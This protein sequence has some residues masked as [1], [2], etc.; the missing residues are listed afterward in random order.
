MSGGIERLLARARDRRGELFKDEDTDVYRLVNG[1]GDGIPG[2]FLDRYG[3]FGV[4]RMESARLR[5]EAYA[6]YAA[7]LEVFGFQGVYEKGSPRRGWD[8]ARDGPDRPV[9]GEAAPEVLVVRERGMRLAARLNEGP[10]TGVYPDQRE[11]RAILA[12]EVREKRVLNTFS[13][14]GAFSV[15]AALAGASATVSVDLS[16]RA[17]Q[18]SE[19]N[20]RL[21]GLD[22]SA[23]RHV[24]ADVFDYLHLAAKKGFRFDVVI[25]DP[26]TFSTSPRGTFRAARDWPRLLAASLAVLDR[27]GLLALSCITRS[28]AE[29]R[30]RRFLREAARA[31]GR[32]ARV[33]VAR[34]LPPDFPPDPADPASAYLKF[35]LV[36]C[37]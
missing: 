17:L 13:Y 26:V 28:L 3:G 15:A 37:S 29:A 7:A 12:R 31:A 24:K 21:N 36:R 23:H 6:L 16:R 30:L 32:T 33:A 10:R 11:N 35:L 20:F 25:L 27:G 8:P 14:T 34:G 2:F 5:A 19:E 22:R 1:G 9:L 4:A 18:W